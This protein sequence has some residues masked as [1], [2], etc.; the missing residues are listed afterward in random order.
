MS[1]IDIIL[2]LVLFGSIVYGVWKGLIRQIASLGGV[3][4]GIIVCRLFG[5]SFGTMLA[6]HFPNTFHSATSAAIVGN[7]LLFGLIWLTVGIAASML[8]KVT[9][10]LMIAWL[11]HLL[12]AVFTFF[13]WMLV[14]SI[15]L[16][17]WHLVASGSSI[18]TTSTLMDGDM[19]PWVMGLAPK[20]FG[21]VVESASAAV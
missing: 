14:L 13:K 5:T 17:L 1:G 10:A 15:L 11:D 9:H 7:V 16:N 6:E 19:L 21:V 20:L 18:F 2:M 3:V 12:G 4:L 8:H